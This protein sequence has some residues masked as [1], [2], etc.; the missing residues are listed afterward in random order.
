M[1]NIIGLFTV[2]SILLLSSCTKVD[3]EDRKNVGTL[4]LPIA[5]F[6]F[7]GNEGPAPVTVNFHNS[8]EYSD[9]WEWRFHN[10]STS[11]EFEPSFTYHNNTGEDMTFQVT[12]TATDTYTGE[13]NTR[14]RVVLVHPSN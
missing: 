6:Y 2:V 9:Q 4:T 1:K 5:S 11:S 14:S 13:T 8:S 7:N 3:E 12:L 10:G